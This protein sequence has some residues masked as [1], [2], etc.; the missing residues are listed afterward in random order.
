MPG[1]PITGTLKYNGYTFDGS[2][3][4]TVE[5]RPIQDEA[6]RTIVML[7]Y[8]LSA[9]WIVQADAGTDSSMKTLSAQLTKQG[10][11]LIFRNKGLGDDLVV[12]SV[13]VAPGQSDIKAGPVPQPLTWKPVGDN[14]AC[15]VTWKCITYLAPTCLSDGNS[16]FIIGRNVTGLL[17]LNYGIEF[18]V[19]ERGYTERVTQGYLQVALTRFGRQIL[20]SADNYL[21]AINVPRLADFHRTTD[22]AI[23]YDKG[24][25]DFSI[26]D[27]QIESPNA[28]PPGVVK[29]RASHRTRTKVIA[30]KPMR[31][32]GE[33]S[34][35]VETAATHSKLWG[36]RAFLDIVRARLGGISAIQGNPLFI[37]YLDIDEEL[38]TNSASY[39]M[40]F[41]LLKKVTDFSAF[42]HW[43]AL[44]YDWRTWKGSID[45]VQS[46]RGI[47]NLTFNQGNDA[48]IDLCGNTG[49]PWYDPRT[50]VIQPISQSYTLLRNDKPSPQ[51]SWLD[52]QQKIYVN[53]ERPVTRQSKMQT[54]DTDQPND[55]PQST[56]SQ[57]PPSGGDNDLLQTSG[58]PRYFVQLVGAARRVGYAVPRPELQSVGGQT[59]TEVSAYYTPWSEGDHLG[60]DVNC[61]AWII[62]YALPNSPGTFERRDNLENGGIA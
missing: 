40:G 23:S 60:V 22:H 9:T 14:H 24:R 58:R 46:Q 21:D 2:S 36:L 26:T 52:Y 43:T 5:I 55:D 19:N 62:T 54:P 50:N 4:L 31:Y 59:P 33:I 49:V 48:I 16:S 57:Y 8:E 37:D 13:S 18:R 7:E 61:G 32:D 25:L 38:F 39:G 51:Q 34:L 35:Q 12:N 15:E 10:Q 45:V 29:I 28:Y 30:G 17:A 44:S 42:R 3:R 47:A 41:R 20:D 27:T 53:R 6:Q 56:S 11:E 1:S